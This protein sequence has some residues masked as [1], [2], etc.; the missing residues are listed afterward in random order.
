MDSFPEVREKLGEL[1][2]YAEILRLAMA[3]VQTDAERAFDAQNSGQ[4]YT[5]FSPTGNTLGMWTAMTSRHVAQILREVGGSGLLMQPSEKDLASPD[6][7]PYLD[8]YM[9]GAGVDVIYKSRLYR[10]GADLTLSTFSNRQE[11]YEYWH[12]GDPTRNR[13]NLFI[14]HDRSWIT[15]RIRQ[16]LEEIDGAIKP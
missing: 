1:C 8:R 6:L 13:T 12:G 15:E 11:L 7:R 10:M 4:R 2:M 3:A 14:R 5:R 16:L 9:R